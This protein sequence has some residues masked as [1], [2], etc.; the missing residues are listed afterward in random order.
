MRRSLSGS[1]NRRLPKKI[2]FFILVGLIIILGY[3]LFN[4]SL[5]V[6]KEITINTLEV[7][8]VSPEEIKNSYHIKGQNILFLNKS[9]I[10]KN[11]KEKY[12]CI[13]SVKISRNFPNKVT[14]EISSRKAMVNLNFLEAKEASAAAL[15][16]QM[17]EKISSPSARSTFSAQLL[18]KSNNIESFTVDEEGII[19]AKT[20][21]KTNMPTVY[22]VDNTVLLGEKIP[23]DL[24]DGISDIFSKLTTYGMDI[25][26]VWIFGQKNIILSSTPKVLFSL[27]NNL[28][29]QLAALQLILNKAKIEEQIIEFID[30][31]FDKPI[32]KYAPKK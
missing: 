10:E 32:V 20:S 4:F 1:N 12:R 15:F 27:N 11:I 14:L 3:L 2:I 22:L 8:C 25:K 23:S 7:G 19:F 16:N 28:N 24:I 9:L 13:K 30:M 29:K 5:L 31:R 26:E 17:I 18:A 21:I 6:I